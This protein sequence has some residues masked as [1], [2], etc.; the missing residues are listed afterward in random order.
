M[1]A[2]L[3]GL[4]LRNSVAPNKVTMSLMEMPDYRWPMFR[5]LLRQVWHR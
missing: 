1:V 2:V 5:V 3:T 4:A